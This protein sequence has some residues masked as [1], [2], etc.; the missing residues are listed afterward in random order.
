LTDLL[1]KLVFRIPISKI[2]LENALFTTDDFPS[3]KISKAEKQMFIKQLFMLR[4]GR[5]TIQLVKEFW[6][7]CR[8]IS[9][10]YVS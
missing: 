2:W 4:G 6:M 8:G 10:D 3:A 7:K 5:G 1:K 9:F